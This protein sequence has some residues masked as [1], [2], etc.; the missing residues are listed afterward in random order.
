MIEMNQ[1]NPKWIQIME[2][3]GCFEEM[4]KE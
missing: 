4:D 1:K 2:E 3:F